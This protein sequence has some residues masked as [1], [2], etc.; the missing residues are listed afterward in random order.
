M[1]E[2]PYRLYSEPSDST[3]GCQCGDSRIAPRHLSTISAVRWGEV[4]SVQ[5]GLTPY[6]TLRPAPDVLS[7]HDEP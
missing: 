5:Y 7:C 6:C 1:T 4:A 2:Q 3:V